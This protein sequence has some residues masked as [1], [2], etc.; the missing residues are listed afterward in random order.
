MSDALRRRQLLSTALAALPL[1]ACAAPQTSSTAGSAPQPLGATREH[2]YRLVKDWD[3]VN[4]IRS[5]DALRKE[6]H[7][8]YIYGGGKLDHLND[9]WQRY[10][11]N[12]NHVFTPD[13]LALVARNVK[14]LTSGGIES[15]MLRSRWSGQY[16][17]FEISMRCP[18][19]LGSWPAFWLNPQDAVW[20]P[21]IDI[22]EIVNNGRDT[23]RHSFHFLHGAGTK[24]RQTRVSRLDRHHRY[25]TQGDFADGFHT[26]AVEWAPEYVRH[27]VDGALIV[28]RDFSWIHNDG[29]DAGDAHVLVNLAIGGKW[30][31]P[32]DA[33]TL[34]AQLDIQYI[35]VWQR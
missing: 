8:R 14:G 9:E 29:R 7:T 24:S 18:R 1:S 5:H 19:G 22:V 23:T 30:P 34:P 31:G 35:R 28:D 11:D 10:R 4:V 17:V 13:G 20:P 12:D 32:P 26:F 15:G 2:G 33:R 3:F 16:G 6:F 25:L 27:Y 21:E